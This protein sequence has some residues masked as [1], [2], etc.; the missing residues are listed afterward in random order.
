[1]AVG[2]P[3]KT[4]YANGDV[5][6]ASDVND[7]NGTI[8]AYVT[9]GPAAGVNKFINADYGVWQ[10][11]TSFNLTSS[12]WTFTADRFQSFCAFSAGTATASRQTFTPATAPVAGY[13]GTYYSRITC[14]STTSTW[15]FRQNIED[16]RTLAGQTVTLSFWIKASAANATTSI[17]IAQVFGSGGSG[18]VTTTLTGPSITTSWQRFSVTFTMP[19]VSGKT[20]GTSSY[21]SITPY[22]AT[23]IASSLVVDTWG[24]QLEAGSTATVFQTATG[25]I[26]GE[27]A[28]C[29]RYYY[30][31]T[32]GCSGQAIAG[33]TTAFEG[34][35]PLKVPMRVNPT[36]L[37]TSGTRLTD[38]ITTA[39]T[40]TLTL[41]AGNTSTESAYLTGTVASGLAQY[42]TYFFN[43][44]SSS[45]YYGFS[46]EL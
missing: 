17:E 13:E 26:Q 12:A 16:V 33:S 42:R 46:A 7:T 20:I 27:L 4:T 35:I 45:G 38:G 34:I 37:D 23:S 29:Q 31:A 25:T 10:R 24:W 32:G 22:S 14:G 40:S 21:V 8:N 15:G 6:S 44:S 5:Y 11:G 3:L 19:S 9:T 41:N 18:T 28:A 1:M 39:N 30:R 43:V 2:L 36:V